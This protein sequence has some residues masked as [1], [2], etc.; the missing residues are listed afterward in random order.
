MW[1]PFRRRVELRSEYIEPEKTNLV[2]VGLRWVMRLVA[3]G[4]ATGVRVSRTRIRPAGWF[5]A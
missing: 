2:V 5:E 1:Q 4:T 3:A